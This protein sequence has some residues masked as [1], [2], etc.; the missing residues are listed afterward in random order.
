M[1]KSET[2]QLST[3]LYILFWNKNHGGGYSYASVG[4][5]H[6]G[7][8]WYA[9]TNWTAKNPEGIACTKWSC[10]QKVIKI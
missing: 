6:D 8:R 5:L 10:V 1:T 3:G 7:T 4:I 9:P 2:H